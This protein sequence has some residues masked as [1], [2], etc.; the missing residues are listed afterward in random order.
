MPSRSGQ[1]T[2]TRSTASPWMVPAD[3]STETTASWNEKKRRSH[4]AS[5]RNAQQYNDRAHGSGVHRTHALVRLRS[6]TRPTALSCVWQYRNLGRHC[7][8]Q[9]GIALK[10]LGDEHA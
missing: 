9:D 6:I 4:G 5:L 7:S 2:E 8:S 10:A 3:F 1:S